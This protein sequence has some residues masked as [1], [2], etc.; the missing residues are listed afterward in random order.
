M[1]L[2]EICGKFSTWIFLIIVCLTQ[3]NM[4]NLNCIC[5]F[6]FYSFVVYVQ[7][8]FYIFVF[9]SVYINSHMLGVT[10]NKLMVFVISMHLL[11]FLA[12]FKKLQIYIK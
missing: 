2:L 7:Y 9:T 8:M 10:N 11:S 6:E 1:E 3:L 4:G 12:S 5:F